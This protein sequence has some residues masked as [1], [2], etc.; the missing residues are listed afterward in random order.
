M[1]L[2]DVTRTDSF[3]GDRTVELILEEKWTINLKRLLSTRN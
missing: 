1:S 3:H 2:I